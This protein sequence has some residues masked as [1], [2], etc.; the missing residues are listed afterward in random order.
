VPRSDWLKAVDARPT[1][2]PEEGAISAS[3]ESRVE[4]ASQTE[5]LPPVLEK[6]RGERVAT[7][8]LARK[9]RKTACAAHRKPGSISFSG[10]QTT[11]T[12]SEAMSKWLDDDGAP[13]APPLSN[14]APPRSSA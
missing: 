12:W 9:K 3:S 2:Q 10:D 1:T 13:V 8:E 11:R 4:G 7:D 14:K 6:A 5:S